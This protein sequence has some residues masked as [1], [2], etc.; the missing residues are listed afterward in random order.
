MVNAKEYVPRPAKL[1]LGATPSEILA[2]PPKKH[3]KQARAAGVLTALQL[4]LA[5]DM[6][7]S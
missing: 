6:T 4:A 2:K 1:G 7:A 5:A 3:V